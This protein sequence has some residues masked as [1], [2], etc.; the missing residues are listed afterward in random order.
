MLL[1]NGY[2]RVD[3]AA[4]SGGLGYDATAAQ[5]LT[6]NAGALFTK[7]QYYNNPL[8]FGNA[9]GSPTPEQ[10][11][12][13]GGV[14]HPAAGLAIVGG[15]TGGLALGPEAVTGIAA[16]VEACAANPVLCANQASIALGELVAST[17]MPAGT[18][19]AV[20]LAAKINNFYRDGA[21][22]DL[23]QQAYN[24][25][26]LS[27]T[28]NASSSEVILGKYIAGSPDSYEA[29]A[30]SRGAT[31]FSMSDWGTVQSQMGADNMWN[32]NKAFLEQ[33]MAQGKSFALTVDPRLVPPKSYTG[34]EYQFFVD[35]G[36]RV[37]SGQG[38]LF[39]VIKK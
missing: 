8:A 7:D 15:V 11:A 6:Q 37:T 25:A 21:S 36:Y 17:A 38:G 5:Y 9:D 27:S 3:G 33:Q 24:Q 26:A 32:I 22:P 19:A 29:V 1:A 16:A 28:H 13:P 18:G 4:A 20:T 10:L 34:L 39:N 2:I 35:S 23:L 30:Q 31:Y 14:P 12:M